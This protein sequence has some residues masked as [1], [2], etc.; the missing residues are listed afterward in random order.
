[1]LPNANNQ[2]R[3]GEKILHHEPCISFLSSSSRV[4]RCTDTV[5]QNA[6][7]L[8]GCSRSHD[9]SGQDSFAQHLPT[10]GSAIALVGVPTTDAGSGPSDGT[11]TVRAAESAGGW[12]HPRASPVE[13]GMTISA[14]LGVE[15]RVPRGRGWMA[16]HDAQLDSSG[17]VGASSPPLNLSWLSAVTKLSSARHSPRRAQFPASTVDREQAGFRMHDTSTR[18][19][20]V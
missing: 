3:M 15:S 16:S 18:T 19:A 17:V 1:M 2:R 8:G 9:G 5:R 12:G 13:T 20:E 11:R 6:L 14:R 4:P 7:L 10:S